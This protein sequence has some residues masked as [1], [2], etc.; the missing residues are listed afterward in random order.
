MRE[1]AMLIGAD[2]TLRP[3]A[4]GGTEIELRVPVTAR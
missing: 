2:L 1:R 4:A 3:A